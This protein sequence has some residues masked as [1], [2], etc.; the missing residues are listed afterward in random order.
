MTLW[1]WLDILL[2]L[3]LGSGVY[4]VHEK[5]YALAAL[6][7]GAFLFLLTLLAKI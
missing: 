4:N 2:I 7:L 3:N 5:N 6:N 1:G